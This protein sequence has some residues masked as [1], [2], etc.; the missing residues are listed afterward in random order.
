MRVAPSTRRHAGRGGRDGRRR[1]VRLDGLDP[2]QRYRVEL[3]ASNFRAPWTGWV[4]L[5]DTDVTP[6]GP[7]VVTV[8]VIVSYLWIWAGFS[9]VVIAAGLAAI[10]RETQEAARVDG[11][12]EWQVFRRVTIPLCGR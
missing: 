11:A 9:M 8:S 6:I 2:A 4:W 12:G 7:A 10:P 3:E 5:G 1:H